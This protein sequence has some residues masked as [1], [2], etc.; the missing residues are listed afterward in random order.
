MP[1]SRIA[2]FAMHE[3]FGHFGES[4][5]FTAIEGIPRAPARRTYRVLALAS[6]YSRW[7]YVLLPAA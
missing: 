4:L 5:L 2:H 7:Q 3:T 1:P 6:K